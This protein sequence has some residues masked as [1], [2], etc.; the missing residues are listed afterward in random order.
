MNA[1]RR[2][3]R[4]LRRSLLRRL[5]VW[6]AVLVLGFGAV[7]A[8]ISFAVGDGEAN[9]Y[10]DVELRQIAALVRRWGSL[11]PTVLAPRGGD[12]DGAAGASVVVEPLG[13][14][15]TQ[16]IARFPANLPD[17]LQ[18]VRVGGTAWRVLVASGASGRIAVAQRAD[19]RTEAATDS[20]QRTLYPLLGLI[21]VLALLM[22]WV[23]RRALRPVRRL[24]EEVDA[25]GE[26]RLDPLPVTD[27]PF[28]IRP[29]LGSINR[30][31]ARLAATRER[32][33]R[34][35]ADAAHELRTPIAA[36]VLQVDNLEH[37]AL[38]PQSRE[39]LAQ[40]RHGLGRTR[41]V[42]EQLLD[43]AR[44]QSGPPRAVQAVRVPAMLRQLGT[45]MQAL[46]ERQ[47]I[48]LHLAAGNAIV[49]T[50]DPMQLYTLV[51][52]ALDNAIRYTPPGGR[53]TLSAH[54][55]S[56]PRPIAVINVDDTGP[57]IPDAQLPRAF[58]PFERLGQAAASGGSGL[59]LAIMREAADNLG[60]EL[61][62]RN[63]A[64]G[65]LRVRIVLPLATAATSTA[66]LRP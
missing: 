20:A 56:A 15:H 30:L 54:A 33:R 49:V 7:T 46:A 37:A 62:L 64:G 55:E 8:A 21:P 27:V 31:I 5:W 66:L 10:Q 1:T 59:G 28:E 41:A 26:H 38:P 9:A 51:R 14:A 34:F 17:G 43:L 32:E 4:W 48:E 39:R 6:T 12:A 44:V 16:G 45:D 63:R 2:L 25:R 52:N 13:S 24:A 19:V 65:G 40:L 58:E 18:T 47:S 29:F 60:A 57:G 3:G 22:G 61:T 35:V 53:V 11:P 42:V 23:V 36:L 50:S